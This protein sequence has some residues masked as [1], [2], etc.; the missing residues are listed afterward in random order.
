M[1]A[2]G[3]LLKTLSPEQRSTAMAMVRS[4]GYG[5]LIRR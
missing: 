1:A 3:P 2:A 5:H 4:A